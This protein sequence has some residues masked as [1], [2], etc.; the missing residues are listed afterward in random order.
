MVVAEALAAE[1]SST[2]GGV[3]R[4]PS[5]L[6]HGGTRRDLL[7]LSPGAALSG[8][9]ATPLMVALILWCLCLSPGGTRSMASSPIGER[10]RGQRVSGCSRCLGT[11]SCG[12]TRSSARRPVEARPED[13]AAG[14]V[15]TTTWV[16]AA[17][18][19]APV[20]GRTRRPASF[21]SGGR[22]AAA[23][24][25]PPISAPRLATKWGRCEGGGEG[26]RLCRRR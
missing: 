24:C 10:Q 18:A 11:S 1:A 25:R 9:T 8:A 19:V 3:H 26:C 5:R 7:P 12:S 20:G 6:P 21:T 2:G 15:D 13:E 16:G 17:A 4:G 23:S 14:N 22:G